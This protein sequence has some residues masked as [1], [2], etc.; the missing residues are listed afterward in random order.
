MCDE[1]DVQLNVE[2]ESF[3]DF[4]VLHSGVDH[5]INNRPHYWGD[6]AAGGINFQFSIFNFQL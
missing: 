3:N 1:Y 2:S 4:R 5:C 6:D